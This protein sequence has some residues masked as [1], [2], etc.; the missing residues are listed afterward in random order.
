MEERTCPSSL[1]LCAPSRCLVFLISISNNLCYCYWA[2]P[3]S[4]FRVAEH[5]TKNLMQASNLGVVWGPTLM[6]PRDVTV[7]VL[8]NIKF[9]GVVIQTLISEYD[10]VSPYLYETSHTKG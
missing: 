10:Q 6:R 4:S 5:S 1:K 2:I 9:Q 3:L 7:A 8:M